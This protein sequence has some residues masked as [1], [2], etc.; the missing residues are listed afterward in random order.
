MDVGGKSVKSDINVTPLVDVVL[1]LLIIF[2]VITPMLQRGKPVQLPRAKMVSELKHGGDPILLSLTGDGRTWLDKVEVKR[3]E[4]SD[5]LV[6]E[7]AVRP[8]APIILKGD[9]SV[10]YRTVRE[11]ILEVSK[12]R[13]VGVSLAASQIKTGE[14]E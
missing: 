2:M 14:A 7:M 1:V 5:A 3:K 12:T 13:V 8:G 10:D 4:L 6:A 9:K 11:V